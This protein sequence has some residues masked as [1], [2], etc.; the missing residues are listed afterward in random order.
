MA[1]AK[2]DLTLGSVNTTKRH[3]WRLCAE[4]AKV[5][6]LR[7]SL[8]TESGT[9]SGLKRRIERRVRKKSF[10]L[11]FVKGSRLNLEDDPLLSLTVL[12]RFAVVA[13]GKHVDVFVCAFGG[14]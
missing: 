1:S 6:V 12:P 5:A 10:R 14:V 7:I 8:I 4:G 2:F 11:M 13:Q 9:G 3:G